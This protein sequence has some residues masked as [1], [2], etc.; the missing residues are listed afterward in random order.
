MT[1]VTAGGSGPGRAAGTEAR[2]SDDVEGWRI[3]DLARRAGVTVDTI[4]FY[5]REGLLPPGLRVGRTQRF[6]PRHLRRLERIA[7]LQERRFSLAAIHALLESEDAGGPVALVASG[8]AAC[9]DLAELARLAGLD[10][11]LASSLVRAG[12]PRD[13]AAVGRTGFDGGDLDALRALA[14]LRAVGVPDHVLVELATAWCR[15]VTEMQRDLVR[16]V[17][18]EVPGAAGAEL[19]ST[20]GRLVAYVHLRTTQQTLLEALGGQV[21]GASRERPAGAPGRRAGARRGRAAAG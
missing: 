17:A 7:Q 5:R 10:E 18:E 13:P 12:I 1:D 4:R 6:G 9:Y 21:A 2:V 3:D 8:D 20:A 15:C 11:D 19:V 14:E 16:L